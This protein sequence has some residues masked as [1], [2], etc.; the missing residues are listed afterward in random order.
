VE[1][2][3]PNSQGAK[4]PEGNSAK[5]EPPQGWKEPRG[6]LGKTQGPQINGIVKKKSN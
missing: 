5:W 3:K 1:N 4:K 6:L 2:W